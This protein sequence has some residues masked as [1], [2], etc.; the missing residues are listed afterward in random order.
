L[1][2]GFWKGKRSRD[3]SSPR[4]FR[5]NRPAPK[6]KTPKNPQAR[7][8][9]HVEKRK[10]NKGVSYLGRGGRDGD[11]ISKRGGENE[12]GEGAVGEEVAH[13]N[14]SERKGRWAGGAASRF[15]GIGRDRGKTTGGLQ[16]GQGI[17]ILQNKNGGKDYDRKKGKSVQVTGRGVATREKVEAAG[18]GK[19]RSW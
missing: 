6:K 5:K 11:S 13:K 19:E 15:S 2:W 8:K 7:E 3:R 14:P 9:V 18:R 16:R 4:R 12:V 17:Q 10:E 1:V